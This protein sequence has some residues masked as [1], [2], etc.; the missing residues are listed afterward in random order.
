M[1]VVVAVSAIVIAGGIEG[2]RF[3]RFSKYYEARAVEAGLRAKIAQKSANEYVQEHAHLSA[4]FRNTESQ[5]K[6][7][8]NDPFLVDALSKDLASLKELQ[9]NDAEFIKQSTRFAQY[10]AGLNRKYERAARYPWLPVEP[11]RP[12]PE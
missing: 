8:P 9:A 2:R 1:M 3:H 11:D 5:L 6:E 10:F 12:A 7:F 4:Q